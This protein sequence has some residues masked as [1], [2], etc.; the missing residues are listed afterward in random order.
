MRVRYRKNGILHSY[1]S[2]CLCAT[3]REPPPVL[4]GPF[5]R[6]AGCP[7]PGHGF[8]C[9]SADGES[10]MR[11]IVARIMEQGKSVRFAG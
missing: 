1:E 10:C 3:P 7:Y 5:Q 9:W 8:L 6:C 11:T 4:T 2:E